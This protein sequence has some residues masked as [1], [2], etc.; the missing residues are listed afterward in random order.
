MSTECCLIL[1][2]AGIVRLYHRGKNDRRQLVIYKYT[3]KQQ[4]LRAA[5]NEAS[6]SGL[7]R[8]STTAGGVP[9]CGINTTLRKITERYW[10][11]GLVEDVRSFC[12]NCAGCYVAPPTLFN[13]APDGDVSE[14]Q[15]TITSARYLT[16]APV[17]LTSSSSSSLF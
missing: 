10:W 13:I 1:D 12:K 2:E 17:S 14:V 5:H 6:A 15:D 4:I 7:G 11:R 8:P 9:H 16:W 3:E